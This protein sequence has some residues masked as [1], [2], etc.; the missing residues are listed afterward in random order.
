ML[1]AVSQACCNKS[2]YQRQGKFRLLVVMVKPSATDPMA[3]SRLV[4]KLAICTGWQHA[5]RYSGD[6]RIFAVKT[7]LLAVRARR[8]VPAFH[9]A[10][11]ADSQQGRCILNIGGIAN[12]TLL[13]PHQAIQGFDTGPGN[14]LLG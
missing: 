6:W 2:G 4:I 3:A 7:L 14:C 13:V 12:I 11:F 9:Q 1:Q 10:I 5:N 8:S